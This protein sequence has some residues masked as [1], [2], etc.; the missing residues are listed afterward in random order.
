MLSISISSIVDIGIV[1]IVDGR[2]RGWLRSV[3]SI[4]I[5]YRQYF[6]DGRYRGWLR[7]VLSISISS[8]VDIGIV[9]I[10]WMVDMVDG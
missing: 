2:Y 6:L 4:S 8:I 9:N 3:L 7:L 1:N 10:L 5:W